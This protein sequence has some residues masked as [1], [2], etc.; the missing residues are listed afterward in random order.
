MKALIL[1]AGLGKR[2]GLKDIPKPMFEID[3]KP[4]LEHNI[5][6]LKKHGIKDIIINLHY[7]PTVIKDFFKDGN[8]WGVNIQYSFEDEL[9]GTSGAVKKIE[10]ELKSEHFFVIYGDNY[11]DINLTELLDF[12]TSN[13]LSATISVFDPKK[14]LNS[15][16]AGGT[17]LTDQENNIISFIEGKTNDSSGYVNAGVYILEP[18][19]LDFIPAN[20]FSD[21]GKDIFPTI[22]K[23]NFPIKA[24]LTD[25]F[26]IAIDTNDALKN[27]YSA[28]QEGENKL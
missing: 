11:T 8:N 2:L 20:C 25:S 17:V 21:F 14:S 3:G 6:L 19:I 5:L 27:A 16:I 23:N 4:I 15:R 22:L 10:K 7:M 9:L 28:L 26:V 1:A 24:Y 13:N 18:N 12:H